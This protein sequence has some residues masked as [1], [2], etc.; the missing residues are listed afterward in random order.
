MKWSQIN[1]SWWTKFYHWWLALQN[2]SEYKNGIFV[3]VAE[4][5]NTL[6][7]FAV[8]K[9]DEQNILIAGGLENKSK[10]TK[11]CKLFNINTFEFSS[12]ADMKN[13]RHYFAL[14]ECNQKYYAVGGFHNSSIECYDKET[15][16]W[17]H[18]FDM[19]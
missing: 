2:I 1:R 19:K 7:R 15:N 10:T 18:I 4:M 3:Q 12:I 9:Y 8:C 16:K 5:E 14:V 17:S 11:K 6:S 13:T